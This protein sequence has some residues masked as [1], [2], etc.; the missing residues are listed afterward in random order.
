MSGPNTN[1]RATV[2]ANVNTYLSAEN[3][4]NGEGCVSP[5]TRC[6]FQILIMLI[7]VPGIDD[8]NNGLIDKQDPACWFCGDGYVDDDP[9]N[10][11]PEQCDNGKQSCSS[12]ENCVYGHNGCTA[13]CTFEVSEND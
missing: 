4:Y 2:L 10:P 8:D 5:A 11:W 6:L 1:C 12:T 9:S 13:S 7:I 3:C